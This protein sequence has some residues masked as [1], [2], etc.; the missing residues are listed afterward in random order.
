MS[1][2]LEAFQNRYLPAGRSRVDA[3]LTVTADP[4]VQAAAGPLVVGFIVDK[5]GSMSVDRIAAVQH[6]VRTGIAMLPEDTW[7]FVVAFDSTAQVV[8]QEVQATPE[9]RKRATDA[10]DRLRAGGGTAMSTGLAAAR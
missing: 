7:F 3:I 6:A 1:F 2:K 4:S 8:V 5:S 10:I 9:N